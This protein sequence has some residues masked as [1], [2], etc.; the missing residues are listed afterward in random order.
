MGDGD[1]E[2]WDFY[3]YLLTVDW[4]SSSLSSHCCLAN[5]LAAAVLSVGHVSCV[6]SEF[7]LLF[8]G[9]C[10]LIPLGVYSLRSQPTWIIMYVIFFCKSRCSYEHIELNVKSH[11]GYR[12]PSEIETLKE[13]TTRVGLIPWIVWIRI[14]LY[15]SVL[16]WYMLSSKHVLGWYGLYKQLQGIVVYILQKK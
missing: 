6:G 15:I 7:P 9:R 12:V 10:P 5:P 13:L 14:A 1:L 4:R 16:C 8:G 2:L 3:F 11:L